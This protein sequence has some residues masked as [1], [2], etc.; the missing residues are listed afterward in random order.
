MHPTSLFAYGTLMFPEILGALTERE[1][2]RQDARL[3]RYRRSCIYE[4]EMKQRPF[5]ALTPDKHHEVHGVIIHDLDEESVLR[6]RFFEEENVLYR[7]LP[8][9]VEVN[10]K[11]VDT[12]AFHW[13]PL[14]PEYLRDEWDPEW[15]RTNHLDEY[16]HKVIPDTV[17]MYLS[18]R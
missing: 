5:P 13:H 10:E 2:P 4:G 6:I 17:Q 8:I 9:T 16:V 3:G 15:F 1:F 12:F 14:R 11:P 18:S 7:L